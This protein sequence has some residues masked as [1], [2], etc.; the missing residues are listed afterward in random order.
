MSIRL[1]PADVI[2][3]IKSSVVITSLNGVVYSLFQNSLDASA[4]KIAVSIDY[5]RGNC[6]VEDDGAGIPPE[7]FAEDG[8][9]GKLYYTSRYPPRLEWHGR[10][11]V[12]LASLATLSLLSVASHHYAYRSHNAVTLHNS[13]VV[14]RN[15][16][17]LPEQEVLA[18][19][20]GTRVT[21][22]DLFGSM[23]VR[24]RQRS[25]ETERLGSAK[26]FDQL[27]LS[28]VALLLA[29]P[30][31]VAV[32]I[33]EAGSNRL[34]SLHTST[35]PRQI[36]S[37]SRPDDALCSRVGGLLSQASL[38]EVEDNASWVPV[39]AFSSGILVTGCVSSQ[40]V[41]TK[42]VQFIA[43][44]IQPLLNECQSNVLYEE[45]N[46]VFANSSFGTIED[47]AVDDVEAP[48]K[49][50]KITQ[51][52]LKVRKGVDR[53]PMFFLRIEMAE[54]P[55]DMDTDRLLDDRG[56]IL[57]KIIS[58]LQ[59]T[60]Y[61][62]LKKHHFCPRSVNAFQQLTGHSGSINAPARPNTAPRAVSLRSK[63]RTAGR[64][65]RST[66]Q[67]FKASPSAGGR[68]AL[69]P[70]ASWARLK[71]TSTSVKKLKSCSSSI[72]P[73]LS[74]SGE[75]DPSRTAGRNEAAV[76]ST[77]SPLFSKTGELLRV[78]F[79]D[80]EAAPA[81][82][83]SDLTPL[84]QPSEHPS[85]TA[86]TEEGKN[87]VW[88]DP[89]TKVRAVVDSRTGFAVR[90]SS[91][92]AGASLFSRSRSKERIPERRWRALVPAILSGT[93][94]DQVFEPVESAIPCVPQI[95]EHLG[96]EHSSH[97]CRDVED[98][99]IDGPSGKISK[100]LES[101]ISKEE[102]EQAEVIK[103]VDR[104]FILV[105]VAS[106]SEAGVNDKKSRAAG[107]TLTG[108]RSLLVLIDQHAADERCR[109]EELLASYFAAVDGMLHAQV[110]D[111]DKPLRFDLS[112]REGRLL[113]RFGGH[114]R[115]WGIRYQLDRGTD[116]DGRKTGRHIVAVHALPCSIAERC[117]LEP[118]LLIELLRKEIW[119]VNDQPAMVIRDDSVTE[120][121]N[122]GAHAWAARF[123]QCPEGIMEMIH[124]R[125][126]RSA[127][128]FNDILTLEECKDLVR[129]LAAC[130]FP[131]Q[132]AHGRPS[133]VPLV[134]LGGAGDTFG[135]GAERPEPKGNM[136]LIGE[137]K[138][139]AARGRE[140]G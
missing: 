117:R 75:S 36:P 73:V 105:K 85:T 110:E 30:D 83:S 41:A 119:K 101:K 134:D 125:S 135:L 64:T 103:Q 43:L 28:I 93:R 54:M 48:A 138:G 9:L 2:A 81:S 96:Y 86:S 31:E 116:S 35:L 131:F 40:P 16:P 3:Q 42:R 92:T 82:E 132:C 26:N 23:P 29:W 76:S 100:T 118:R 33:R 78:P 38:A 59:I 137:L 24:V 84:A 7:D 39:G 8:G 51:R 58:L 21:V 27:I 72:S 90:S 5:A 61:E 126:C 99:N 69:S 98:V 52:S 97:D 140:D 10:H 111:L 91:G 113:D 108:K 79:D 6:S 77:W 49:T 46:K 37:Q 104:K 94:K 12:F 25:I 121:S 62:F 18:H 14:A 47:G 127:I 114:F 60:A 68:P 133:M 15:T 109:V 112:S 130:A 71:S 53:W 63:P 19:A 124:S 70:F 107:R 122:K 129:R 88:V 139:W 55:R 80:D 22:R 34:I 67:T 89:A 50:Y 120:G 115:Y 1:L 136:G 66:S 128:M 87:I 95:A 74:E 4:S 123:H 44:G 65:S 106:G 45:V 13:K 32:T 102:L 11:G 20:S 57:A 17:A 56:G